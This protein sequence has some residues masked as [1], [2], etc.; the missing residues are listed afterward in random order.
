MVGNV[1][2]GWFV[3]TGGNRVPFD[4]GRT[5]GSVS[6]DRFFFIWDFGS[7][8]TIKNEIKPHN[9]FLAGLHVSQPEIRGIFARGIAVAFRG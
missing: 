4:G 9:Y 5:P 3:D 8:M 6:L 1:V 7:F 2:P